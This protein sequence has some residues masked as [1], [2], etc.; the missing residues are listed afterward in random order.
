MKEEG[1]RA[2]KLDPSSLEKQRRFPVRDCLFFMPKETGKVYVA[3]NL[4][5][6]LQQF[7]EVKID[8]FYVV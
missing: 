1:L 2:A 7:T 6:F 4:C 8:L 5:G 3:G